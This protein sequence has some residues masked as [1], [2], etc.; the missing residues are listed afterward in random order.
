M[1]AQVH[2][3]ESTA[4]KAKRAKNWAEASYL[5]LSPGTRAAI[6]GSIAV[7]R[8]AAKAASGL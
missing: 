3:T 6:K 1:I 2:K 7:V 8:V 4:L 5:K